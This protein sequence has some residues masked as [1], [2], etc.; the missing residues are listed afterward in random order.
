MQSHVPSEEVLPLATSF[1][2]RTEKEGTQSRL[3]T[4]SYGLKTGDVRA[5]LKREIKTK[6]ADAQMTHIQVQNYKKL[7]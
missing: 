4:V 5:V 2:R 6:T 7:C 1:S 3:T